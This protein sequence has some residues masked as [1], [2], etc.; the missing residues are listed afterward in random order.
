MLLVAVVRRSGLARYYP[1][2]ASWKINCTHGLTHSRDAQ[3]PTLK[4][5][6]GGGRR[7]TKEIYMNN[8]GNILP[9]PYKKHL[10]Y[11]VSARV[12]NP[13]LKSNIEMG[14]KRERGPKEI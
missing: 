4:L 14:G 2:P 12:W 6:G 3:H 9:M 11:Y 7:I 10:K 1:P 5:G 13:A 8:V